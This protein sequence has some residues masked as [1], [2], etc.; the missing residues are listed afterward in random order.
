MATSPHCAD[1][2]TCMI[3]SS[4]GY[5]DYTVYHQVEESEIS[6]GPLKKSQDRSSSSSPWGAQTTTRISRSNSTGEV[7]LLT[8]ARVDIQSTPEK[9]DECPANY[10]NFSTSSV[11]SAE[12][13]VES[14]TSNHG[15]GYD[16]RG[17]TTSFENFIPKC[18]DT[19]EGDQIESAVDGDGTSVRLAD[20][21]VENSSHPSASGDDVLSSVLKVFPNDVIPINLDGS[22]CQLKSPVICP[23]LHPRVKEA[24]L[25][26]NCMSRFL[27]NSGRT[28]HDFE[29]EAPQRPSR[30]DTT[31]GPVSSAC[32]SCCEQQQP[33]FKFHSVVDIRTY[34]P[35][36]KHRKGNEASGSDQQVA[37]RG[38]PS[39]T[40]TLECGCGCHKTH[41]RRRRNVRFD[42]IYI[43]CYDQTIGDNPTVS[44]GTPISLDWHY[45]VEEP[46]PID[47]FEATRAGNRQKGSH[48]AIMRRLALNYFQRRSRLIYYWGFSEEEVDEAEKAVDK[49]RRQRNFT[50][51]ISDFWWLEDIVRTAGRKVKRLVIRKRPQ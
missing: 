4:T 34:A 40:S 18:L 49:A 20:E 37:L 29:G 28:I 36:E 27:H 12:S 42:T 44:I 22:W 11:T 7:E 19:W 23:K 3:H 13:N 43:R 5:V 50:S 6:S 26:R 38:R 15:T 31:T 24:P 35:A 46:M 47:D 17:S 39:Q 45:S 51:S 25:D 32:G 33:S 41:I 48:G 16:D 9:A 10:N 21:A 1:R 30:Q 14:E 2:D 8:D